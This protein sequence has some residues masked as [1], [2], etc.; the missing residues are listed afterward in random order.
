MN[1]TKP[2]GNPASNSSLNNSQQA[3]F[4]A[5]CNMEPGEAVF[6]TGDAGTGKS[7]LV[8][9]IAEKLRPILTAST[10]LA[11]V[12]IGGVT[13]HSFF[14]IPIQIY[15][16]QI[17]PEVKS[18]NQSI[19]KASEYIVIDECSMLRSDTVDA[20]D[21]ACRIAM[22]ND[23]KFGGKKIVFVGDVFQLGPIVSRDEKQLFFER[24]ESERFFG[25]WVIG[26]NIKKIILTEPMR[27]SDPDLLKALDLIKYGDAEGL[28]FFNKLYG[29]TSK[30]DAVRIVGK[31][32]TASEE[33]LKRLMSLPSKL[34]I[35]DADVFGSFKDKDAPVESKLFLKVGARVIVCK[36][37][38]DY[39]NGEIGE[40]VE[41]QDDT[42]AVQIDDRRVVV[43]MATW[44]SGKLS[45]NDAGGIERVVT[46]EFKQIPLKL[47]YAI[48]V[49][50]SQGQTYDRVHIDLPYT[51]S[52]GQLYVALSRC[53]TTDGLS[54][55]SRL[56]EK[57]LIVC[58]RVVA[59]MKG[60]EVV[61]G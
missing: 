45:Q 18:E 35:F 54:L 47:G 61:N 56:T 49:H 15:T 33:N 31:N 40:V 52:P 4:D 22:K 13:C 55:E 1:K 24:Y 46:G 6:L 43:G 10:G 12:N 58:P 23:L 59:F 60:V 27:Q 21:H 25:A 17:P 37:S 50:K 8:R 14:G 32:D 9:H 48:T 11:A 7:F 16:P 38:P 51:F 36:N 3:A 28:K 26:G 2:Q 57:S 42:V 29:K 30:R 20:I 34:H 39:K 41:I 53:R 5:I 19:I 44:D